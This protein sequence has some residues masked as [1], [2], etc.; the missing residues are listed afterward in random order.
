[1]L[2]DEGLWAGGVLTVGRENSQKKL[3]MHVS[4]KCRHV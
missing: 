3:H 1:M 4:S 2:Q